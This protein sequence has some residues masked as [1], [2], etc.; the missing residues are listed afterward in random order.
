MKNAMKLHGKL[1]DIALINVGITTGNNKYFSV[2]R[3]TVEKYQ[4]K[5]I[6]RPLIGRNSHANSIY[7]KHEDWVQNV[8]N[9]KASYLIDFPEIEYKNYP[10]KHREYI[11]KGERN[12]ENKGNIE[13]VIRKAESIFSLC[14]I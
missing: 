7:F 10:K 5:D 14:I 6:V 1:S 13:D 2:E 4:M 9:N 12:G 11:K 8:N 3:E